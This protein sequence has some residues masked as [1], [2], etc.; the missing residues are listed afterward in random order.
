M[1]I[2]IANGFFSVKIDIEFY[3]KENPLFDNEILMHYKKRKT[4]Q[5][6]VN[7]ETEIKIIISILL[8]KNLSSQR[9]ISVRLKIYLQ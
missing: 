8:E 1:L 2:K 3:F 9:S 5:T 6:Y 4:K 7:K